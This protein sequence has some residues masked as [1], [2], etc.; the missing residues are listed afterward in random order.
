MPLRA[1]AA[2][3]LIVVVSVPGRSRAADA[4]RASELGPLPE[5]Q[6]DASDPAGSGDRNEQ[7]GAVS[8][9]GCADE[10]GIAAVRGV[11]EAAPGS[12]TG[13]LFRS[14]LVPGYGQYYNGQPRK[15]A[16]FLGVEVALL[17]TALAFH[18]GGDKVLSLYG[19]AASAQA[20]SNSTGQVQQ[21]YES[22]QARFQVRDALLLT[23]SALWA[24]NLADAYLSGGGK[25]PFVDS[26][27]QRP[28]AGSGFAPLAAIRPGVAILGVQGRF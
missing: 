26:A 5:R 10:L 27:D 14:M 17:S 22:A 3:A 9:V 12:R 23:A 6:A 13:A 7:F 25:Q 28:V 2:S 18:L 24:I 4:P 20:G 1:I 8:R 11:A 15:A 19:R 16:V 21:L